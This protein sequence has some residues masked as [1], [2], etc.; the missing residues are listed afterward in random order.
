MKACHSKKKVC[1]F[2]SCFLLSKKLK[3]HHFQKGHRWLCRRAKESAAGSE[4]SGG[5]PALETTEEASPRTWPV[6]SL[7]GAHAHSPGLPGSPHPWGGGTTTASWP[8]LPP[9]VLPFCHLS[10]S[11]AASD[12]MK[13]GL[14]SAPKQRLGLKSWAVVLSK[15]MLDVHLKAL[16]GGSGVQRCTRCER[17]QEG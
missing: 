16:G 8:P 9:P 7:S 10:P 11:P 15:G 2:F 4:K 1:E 6:S 17:H 5:P 14:R 13:P 12:L 3:N